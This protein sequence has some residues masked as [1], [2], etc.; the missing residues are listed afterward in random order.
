MG[1]ISK[2][3]LT[4][5]KKEELQ[6]MKPECEEIYLECTR[7]LSKLNTKFPFIAFTFDSKLGFLN[8]TNKNDDEL[9]YKHFKNL[10]EAIQPILK[11]L[12]IE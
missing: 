3:P 1:Y 6:K 12:D 10:S 4:E 9:Y 5:Q 8:L 11:H 7:N 2:T